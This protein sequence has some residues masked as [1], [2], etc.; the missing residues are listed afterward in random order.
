MEKL[1]LLL[2]WCCYVVVIITPIKFQG[3]K[4]NRFFLPHA[5]YY[6]FK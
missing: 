1:R 4:F 6:A 2:G 5:G 3:D